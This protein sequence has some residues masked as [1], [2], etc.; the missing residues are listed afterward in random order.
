MH[1]LP[2]F[3]TGPARRDVGM[4][5]PL[6]EIEI[7]FGVI[8]GAK[9]GPRLLVTAGVHGSQLC[10]IETGLRLLRLHPSNIRGSVMVLP[11]LNPGGFTAR[12]IYVMPRMART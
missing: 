4:C 5:R 12:S 7:P 9:A 11:L 3:R 6:P 2:A 1:Q 8:E 10:A